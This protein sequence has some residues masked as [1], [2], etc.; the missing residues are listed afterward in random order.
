MNKNLKVDVNKLHFIA[1]TCWAIL[2][3]SINKIEALKEISRTIKVEFGEYFNPGI[4]SQPDEI[5]INFIEL[6]DQIVFEMEKQF[7]EDDSIRDYI[8]DDLYHRL[9]IYLEVLNDLDSYKKNLMRKILTKDDIV[10][11]KHF[12]LK[13]YIDD[14]I[15]TFD[16]QQNLQKEILKTL[17]S[18]DN[19]HLLQFYYQV[20]KGV[21]CYETRCLA[22][23]GLKNCNVRFKN[24]HKLID[25]EEDE[26]TPLVSYVKEMNACEPWTNEIPK[27]LSSLTLLTYFA[28]IFFEKTLNS[29]FYMWLFNIFNELVN[30]DL[31]QSASGGIYYSISSVLIKL[32][33]EF[34][35]TIIQ[36]DELL[37]SFIKIIDSLPRNYF[38]RVTVKL[39]IL[40]DTF[41]QRVNELV[42]LDL[43]ILQDIESNTQTYLFWKSSQSI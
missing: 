25:N 23:L 24:W 39:D 13:E 29:Q 42:E 22:L 16:E 2:D 8:T 12:R 37:P 40:G 28:D 19:E 43:L 5:S 20:V 32:N 18:F 3:T 41:V 30:Y 21:Y 35:N 31:N 4:L 26:L 27:E 38:D 34:Y 1:Q 11:I 9:T 7:P 15:S 6:M 17:L 10:I 36:S 33:V 14:I